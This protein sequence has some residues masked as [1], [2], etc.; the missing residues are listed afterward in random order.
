MSEVSALTWAQL[1]PLIAKRVS[2]DTMTR[3]FANT[4]IAQTDDTNIVLEVPNQIYQFWIETN[5]TVEVNEA[6]EEACGKRRLSFQFRES[7][8]LA[9]AM[10]QQPETPKPVPTEAAIPQPSS[11]KS[12][13]GQKATSAG[14]NHRYLF[15]SFVVGANN[16][17]AH[18]ACQA[19]AS[20]P[21]RIYNPL[22]IYGGAGMGKTHLMHAIGHT[23]LQERP[24]AKV[25]YITSEQF[26]NEFI[27]A[28]SDGSLVKFRQQYREA[29]VLLIDDIQFF[30]KKEKSQEEFFH[31]FNTL[32]DKNSKQIVMTSDMPASKIKNLE[33]R[34]VSRFEWGLTAEMAPP[35]TETRIAILKRKAQEMCVEVD[36]NILEFIAQHIRNNVRRLEGALIRLAS[37]GSMN[38]GHLDLKAVEHLLQD[39]LHDEG[40]KD[41]SISQIQ[42]RVAE[43]YDIR[44][45]DILGRKRPAQI[46]LARQVAM[47]FSRE[48]TGSSYQEIGDAFGG[49]D[50]GTVIHACRS[51]EAKCRDLEKVRRQVDRLHGE[52]TETPER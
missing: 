9:A 24:S 22:F 7:D 5:Y 35:D 39:F 52:F 13:A 41:V 34:L 12:K 51:V 43:F 42:K 25:V 21:G 36:G 48:L 46:A 3:W 44:L 4:S 20:K 10:P 31:T 19:A 45:S 32:C 28:I 14:L 50:H 16:E 38:N 40:S 49:R 15:E 8:P 29:D 6:I 2:Q 37:F 17:F 11:R 27:Q 26:T 30:A 47:F 23:I 1:E 18:A 33:K